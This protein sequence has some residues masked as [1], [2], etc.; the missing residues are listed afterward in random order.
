VISLLREIE[1][2]SSD[3]EERQEKPE[4]RQEVED[5]E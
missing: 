4:I 1:Y 5:I 2:D 3:E